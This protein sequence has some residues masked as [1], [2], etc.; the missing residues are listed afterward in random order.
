MGSVLATLSVT[1]ERFFAIVLPLKDLLFLKRKLIPATI[2][3]AGNIYVIVYVYISQGDK[4]CL[5]IYDSIGFTF[6]PFQYYITFRHSL[7][8][9]PW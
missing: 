3:I 4:Y 5:E 6:L 1:I 9:Q 7:K 2:L 8:L